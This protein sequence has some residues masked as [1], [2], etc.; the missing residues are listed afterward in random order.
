MIP[1]YM[2]TFYR[3]Y[4]YFFSV[5]NISCKYKRVLITFYAMVASYCQSISGK[6]YVNY[7]V[8]VC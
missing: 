5:I 2:C 6:W 1:I 7:S 8:N 4:L 3:S